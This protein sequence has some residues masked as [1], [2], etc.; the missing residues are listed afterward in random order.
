MYIDKL[1]ETKDPLPVSY[2]PEPFKGSFRD[3][4]LGKELVVV[5][6]EICA[7][8]ID[9]KEWVEQLINDYKQ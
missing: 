6:G 7:K 4:F 3:F 2:I 8:P 5:D 1:K 9:V